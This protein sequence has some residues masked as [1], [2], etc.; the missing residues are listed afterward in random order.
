MAI[1]I[2]NLS[3]ASAINLIKLGEINKSASGKQT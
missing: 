2:I 1:A 3:V